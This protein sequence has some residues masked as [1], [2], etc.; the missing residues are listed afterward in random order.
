MVSAIGASTAQHA[1][2]RAQ[3][4][5]HGDGQQQR[6]QRQR[7][8]HAFAVL[9][10]QRFGRL[11]EVEQLRAVAG[12][13]SATTAPGS[14][15]PAQRHQRGRVVRRARS[16]RP[17]T[18][19]ASGVPS[20]PRPS[21]GSGSASRASTSART[22]RRRRARTACALA[23]SVA[24]P[25]KFAGPGS[26]PARARCVALARQVA[27]RRSNSRRAR[28]LPRAVRARRSDSQRCRTARCRAPC[29]TIT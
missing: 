16:S 13:A 14:C 5:P 7:P 19:A 11:L 29:T 18:L 23:A 26:A 25:R 20:S 4:E 2:R 27:R 24:A 28:A 6:G 17:P 21:A 3:R 15:E 22:A 10:D 1:A 9:G 12:A 8:Q